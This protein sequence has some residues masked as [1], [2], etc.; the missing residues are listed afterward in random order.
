MRCKPPDCPGAG[1]DFEDRKHF[2]GKRV[3]CCGLAGS[4]CA[5][6]AQYLAAAGRRYDAAG[7][8]TVGANLQRQTLAR[9][10]DDALASRSG[11]RLAGAGAHQPQ[12]SAPP[13]L[14]RDAG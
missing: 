4:G 10:D 6:A 9:S 5:A 12:R 7:F 14:G 2:G 11:L 8:D 1:S 3:V 13:L